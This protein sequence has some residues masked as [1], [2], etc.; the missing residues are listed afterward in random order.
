MPDQPLHPFS[1]APVLLSHIPGGLSVGTLVI[2]A[3][4]AVFA[5]WAVYTLVAIYHWLKYSHASWLAFP[6]IV[7]H[8]IISLSLISYALGG[9]A[10]FLAAYLP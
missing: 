9:G 7:L 4:Y 1:P 6:A 2:W 3:L 5:F 10:L 8:L